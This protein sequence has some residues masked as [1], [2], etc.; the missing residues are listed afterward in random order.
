MLL[1]CLF[2]QPAQH[3]V[4]LKCHFSWQMQH[5]V[6]LNRHF[7]W[8]AH[9][10]RSGENLGDSRSTK[11][12]LL[13][14]FSIILLPQ[15]VKSNLGERGCEMTCPFMLESCSNRPPK[16]TLHVICLT[17]RTVTFRGR[18][19]KTLVMLQ[20]HFWWQGQHLVMLECHFS[21]QA[22]SSIADLM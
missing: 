11:C 16:M 10:R 14:S 9:C 8:Q 19:K 2:S 21:W 6:P 18:H 13:H 20:R 1:K 4:M 5:L 22:Y 7:S 15:R 12:C 17:N 3:L